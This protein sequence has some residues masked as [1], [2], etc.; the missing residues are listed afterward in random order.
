M[1]ENLVLD[2]PFDEPDGSN[3]AYD[4]SPGAHHAAIEFGRFI[5]GRFGNCA[6]F[7][8]VGKAEIV[9]PVINFFQDFTFMIWLMAEPYNGYPTKTFAQFKFLGEE[10]FK[11][12]TINS[13]LA[14]WTH[15]TITQGSSLLALYMN[16]S[17]VG[18][19]FHDSGLPP[20]GF[21]ILNDS[22]HS[23]GGFCY[24]DG[25]KIIQGAAIPPE[26][27]IDIIQNTLQPVNFSVN[28]INFKDFGV[29][30]DGMEGVLDMPDR[31]D[32]LT[33]DWEDYHGEV[34]DLLK[35]VWGVRLIELS[36][37]IKGIGK[38]DFTA[39]W[40]EFKSH[41]EQPGTVRVQIDAG[42]K[43]LLFEVYHRER[44]R[45]VKGKWRD[46]TN[47]AR[48]TLKLREPEPVKR[49][50]KV[51]GNTCSITLTSRKIVSVYWGDGSR[52]M[53]VYGTNKTVS[54]NY[55]SSGEY[56]VIVAGVIEDITNFSSNAIVVWDK[57]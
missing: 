56:Y 32:P 45:N 15:L 21:S 43:P 40:F 35:P 16:G 51:S 11:R 26:E 20:T 30:V 50:L 17:K 25:G 4:Y 19:V 27:I 48:F 9:P 7:P 3:I 52:T 6:Y 12:I 54:H 22:P 44:L 28:N 10:N 37:W 23:T 13:R 47:Y 18:E 36:C 1:A 55:G 8:L 57:I 33:M 34:V 46:G 39:K 38:D 24:L 14:N 42:S 49:V 41:F 31:K 2:I 5:P 29:T 53:N